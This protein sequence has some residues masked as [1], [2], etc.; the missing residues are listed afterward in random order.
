[1]KAPSHL[2]CSVPRT[3]TPR[4]RRRGDRP[5]GPGRRSLAF[6][7]PDRRI[8]DAGQ[9]TRSHH[10]CARRS[11][12]GERSLPWPA[13]TGSGSWDRLDPRRL[14]PRARALAARGGAANSKSP[15]RALV[16]SVLRLYTHAPIRVNRWSGTESRTG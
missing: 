2:L 3:E 9:A 1:M 13:G 15:T 7:A 14:A 5:A 8:R 11:G 16:R 6:P 10:P 4:G 12:S